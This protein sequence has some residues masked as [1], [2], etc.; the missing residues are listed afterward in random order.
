MLFTD[1]ITVL[2]FYS[3][4]IKY[5]PQEVLSK[6]KDK[7]ITNNIFRTQYNDSFVCGFYCVVFIKYMI[8]GKKLLDYTNLF[9]PNGYK[10]NVNIIYKYFKDKYGK[11]RCKPWN[12]DK[13]IGY[14]KNYL[15]K[16]RK[17]DELISSNHKNTCR[18]LNYGEQFFILAS[19][20]SFSEFSLLVDILIG[21]ESSKVTI[22]MCRN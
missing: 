19:T 9:S 22:K 18:N 4:E 13:K 14:T 12:L 20:F 6:I 17:H 3:I 21:I 7:P 8:A 11:R 10:T 2:F 15:L 5:V 16:E 1:K